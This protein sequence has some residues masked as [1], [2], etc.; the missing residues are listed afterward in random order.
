MGGITYNGFKL[1]VENFQA[2]MSFL[3][4]I[5][6]EFEKL[7]NTIIKE[8]LVKNTVKNIDYYIADQNGYSPL[9]FMRKENFQK[10]HDD[11]NNIDAFS[12][13]PHLRCFVDDIKNIFSNYY[14]QINNERPISYAWQQLKIQMESERTPY[15]VTDGLDTSMSVF[16]FEKDGQFYLQLPIKDIRKEKAIL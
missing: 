2:A 6:P 8:K 12:L 1:N 7:K 4:K 13:Y 11:L 15:R 10:I 9:S 16:L 5:K 14:Y 3:K